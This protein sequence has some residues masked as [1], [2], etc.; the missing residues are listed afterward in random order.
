MR[1][2]FL[3]AALLAALTAAL[4]RGD[5]APSTEVPKGVT[6]E[7]LGKFKVTYYWVTCEDDAKGERDTELLDPRGKTLGRF[8]AD[9]VKNLKLE[10]TGRTLEGKTL[11]FAGEDRYQFVKHPWGTG[12][13]ERPL[14]PFRSIAVDPKVIE[15]GTKIL[16]PQA[17]GALLPDGST[18][19]GI[20]V[21]DD[22]G[23]GIKDKHIDL[24]CGLKRDMKII[25]K[26]GVDDD[27]VVIHKVTKDERKPPKPIAFPREASVRFS[28]VNVFKTADLDGEVAETL[29]DG[30]KV[31]VLAKDGAFWKLGQGKFVEGP[32]LDLR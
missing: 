3:A 5:D 4:A 27:P 19:D 17:V 21:A 11:N 25:A 23:S 30:Q 32:A 10:G 29:K 6:A 20:F 22:T 16:I 26:R 8:R 15:I 1:R 18:H 12:W 7:S 28:K 9:F 24:F 2:A 13:K 31:K 14:E